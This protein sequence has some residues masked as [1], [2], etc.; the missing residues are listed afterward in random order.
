MIGNRQVT[1]LRASE[2]GSRDAEG[3]RTAGQYAVVA[4]VRGNVFDRA[5]T[6]TDND[7][8]LITVF[9]STALLPPGTDVQSRDLLEADGVRYRVQSV[10]LRRG[11][12]GGV[13]HVSAR[14]VRE[15]RGNE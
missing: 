1:V 10:T 9:D 8:Q 3:R 4:S 13:H 7:G 6:Y 12:F 5:M 11:P 14:C 2:D 15:E